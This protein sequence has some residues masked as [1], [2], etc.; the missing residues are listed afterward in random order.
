MS[1]QKKKKKRK[2]QIHKQKEK[3]EAR[4][5]ICAYNKVPKDLVS[6]PDTLWIDD[7]NLA[8][9]EAFRF[10]TKPD[11]DNRMYDTLY[12][13]D[14]ALY[15]VKPNIM[16]IGL[17]KHQAY[18]F[19]EQRNKGKRKI[20]EVIRYWNKKY[21]S[22]E[23]ETISVKT[24]GI[25]DNLCSRN[26][27]YVP[28]ELPEKAPNIESNQN[29]EI[30]ESEDV[31]ASIEGSISQRTEEFN[32]RLRENPHD[33]NMWMDFIKF[34]EE[35]IVQGET[36]KVHLNDGKNEQ[37]KKASALVT[38]KKIAIFEKALEHNPNSLE[39]MTA[40]LQLSNSVVT[41]EKLLEKWKKIIFI[42]PNKTELWKQY[43][44]FAQS[45]FSIFSFDKVV[46]IYHKCLE[47]LS[48][49]KEG[50]FASHKPEGNVESDML[51]LFVLLCHFMRQ[52][53]KL[54]L[55]MAY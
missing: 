54:Q 27:S 5:L 15:K 51:D 33:V 13:L 14:V 19:S 42:H 9:S 12:R 53:G 11:L 55:F 49:I 8:P 2:K 23:P 48:S 28:V 37:R 31:N 45:N 7:V 24:K 3:N 44:H 36:L 32:K 34:Q 43:I 35:A 38:E 4:K 21:W 1:H 18:Q 40:H 46:S 22:P 41:P 47:T 26:Y 39:L 30:S 29:T 50:K 25:S 6:K 10:S 16:C 20:Q 52:S 17:N